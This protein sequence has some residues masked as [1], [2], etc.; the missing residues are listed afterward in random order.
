MTATLSALATL[1]LACASNVQA[2]TATSTPAPSASAVSASPVARFKLK[3]VSFSPTVGLTPVELQA[4][5]APFVGRDIS[6]DDLPKITAAVRRSYEERGL[7]LVAIGLPSQPLNDGVLQVAIVEP[8]TTRLLVDSTGKAPVSDQRAERVLNNA[9]VATGK[10]LNLKQLDRAM[11]TLNDW[12][13]VAAKAT[14]TPSGD[15][16]AYT[17]AVQTHAGRAW[18]ASVDAD[19]YGTKVSGRYRVGALLRWNNPLSIGD[20]L[21]LRAVLANG[22]NNVVGR[23]GYEA[24]I[25]ATPWRGGIGY[26]RVNYELGDAFEGAVGTADVVDASLSY[27]VLRTRD[28]NVISRLSIED[29]KL[30]DR[31]DV[32]ANGGGIPTAG[33]HTDKH[34]QAATLTLSFESRDTFGGGGFSGG[35]AGLTVG[36]LRD[37]TDYGAST[38]SVE[39]STLGRFTKLSFQLTRL[40]AVSRTFSVF[41][42]LAGQL[43]EKNLDNAEKLTLGGAKG[44][45]AYPSAEGA[46][47]QGVIMNSELR[48]WVSPQWSSYLFYDVGHGR[49]LRSPRVASSVTTLDNTRTLHGAGIGVQYTNPDLL[50]LKA[51]LAR[52]GSEEVKSDTDNSRALLLVQA[53]H[54]F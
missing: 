7:G 41:V 24:P 26:S 31:F 45:R 54:S 18:D 38:P 49:L 35:S 17:V 8:R 43:A 23:L 53:Q 21:D 12:P 40:Q 42:G 32:P 44:V 19:N 14:L 3:A 27:P 48:L 13:G 30:D 36:R 29:K 16:G 34:I 1:G 52:R 20:N 39:S 37:K 5:V 9:G 11:F 28:S 47:D 50:T 6:N 4:A 15:E 33:V 46:S 25:G 22:K 10:P 2:Q 51:S